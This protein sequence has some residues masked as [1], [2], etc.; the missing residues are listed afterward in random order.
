MKQCTFCGAELQDDARACNNCGR[1]VPDMPEP[2]QEKDDLSVKEET[3]EEQSVQKQDAD[4]IQNSQQFPQGQ[5]MQAQQ[6]QSQWSS[7]DHTDP[8]EQLRSQWGSQDQT[9]RQIPWGQQEP[10]EQQD[11]WGQQDPWNRQNRSGQPQGMW[12]PQGQQNQPGQQTPWGWQQNQPVNP[13]YGGPYPGSGIPQ[14]G[15]LQR[16]N[17]F[18]LWSLILGFLASF[19]NGVVFIPSILAII[20]SIIGIIQIRKNPAAFKGIWMAVAGLI[21]GVIFLIFY[22][23][24]FHI[25]IQIVQD[26]EKLEQLQQYMQELKVGAG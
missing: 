12:N 2:G 9:G 17:A 3:A 14:N 18:A 8:A 13:Y 22:G 5:D 23:Y 10:R 24:I 1:P 26:P 21:L 11:P 4:F 15:Q 25:A 16:Y 7:E 20:F 6:P 19:L